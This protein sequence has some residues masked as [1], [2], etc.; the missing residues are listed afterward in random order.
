MPALPDRPPP[1]LAL[2]IRLLLVG[3][4]TAITAASTVGGWVL[5]IEVEDL[6]QD[7]YLG[8]L[9]RQVALADAA[10]PL[11]PGVVRLTD[12]AWLTRH[13]DLHAVPTARGLHEIF[14]DDE[15]RRAVIPR[16]PLDHVKLW[17]IEPREREYRLWVEPAEEGRAAVWVLADLQN[18][19]FSET[20]LSGVQVWLGVLSAGILLAS[21]L[22]SAVITRWALRPMLALAERVRAREAEREAGRHDEVALASGLPDDEIGYL[23][24]MLD[25]YHERLRETL[26]RER[27]F[28][29]DCSHELRT[30]VTTLKGATMLLRELPPEAEARER[31]LARLERSVRRMERL[32]QTFL[33][34]A[35]E[36]R[37]PEPTGEVDLAEVV[38]EVV[39]EWRALHSGHAL[40]VEVTAPEPVR[41]RCHREG[42]A[43]LAHNLIGNAF[44]H[45][46]GGRLEITVARA[47]SGVAILRFEDDGPGLPEFAPRSA[48]AEKGGPGY[49]LGLSLVDRLCAAQGWNIAKRPRVGGGT[50]IEVTVRDSAA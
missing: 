43:V 18:R 12:A 4:A 44:A 33:M 1:R 29:A 2:R 28:I 16:G 17:L 3:L 38:R 11:P 36:K 13:H 50:W 49:G 34:L 8:A 14:A 42:V 37:L 7:T 19:E 21:L 24:R 22:A 23:A 27:R 41:V 15:G 26:T 39:D 5:L 20:N 31:L 35:R 40:A 25:A 45:L 47:A 6:V 30:P 32:I 10:S 46:A 9:L 48:V